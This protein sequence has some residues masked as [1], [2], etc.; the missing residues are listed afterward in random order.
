MPLAEKK[1]IIQAVIS[2][3]RKG[4]VAREA[5]AALGQQKALPEPQYAM[6]GIM[7]AN[8]HRFD[9]KA[10]AALVLGA[11]PFAARTAI[12]LLGRHGGPWAKAE[13]AA[14]KSKRKSLVRTITRTEKTMGAEALPDRANAMLH[15]ILNSPTSK[16]KDT[17]AVVMAVDYLS[18]AKPHLMEIL[19]SPV[20]DTE[21]TTTAVMALTTEETDVA[22]LKGYAKRG[23]HKILRYRAF[24]K[25]ADLGAEGRAVLRTFAAVPDEPLKPR[26]QEMLSTK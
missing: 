1:K 10:L 12:E 18:V 20:A 13:L 11:N 8:F 21:T 7:T 23:N 9:Q 19:D 16:G 4:A 2:L 14:A 15:Q 26:I 3:A 22:T 25:L 6:G 17:A 24:R 5:L